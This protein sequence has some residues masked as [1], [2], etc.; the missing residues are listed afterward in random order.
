MA[1]DI[2]TLIRQALARQNGFDPQVRSK[3]Y[4]SSRNA[5]AKMIAKSGVI[6]PNVIDARNRSLEDTIIRIEREFTSEVPLQS[7][8]NS[9]DIG[10][11]NIG[12]SNIEQS[13]NV[14]PNIEQSNPEQPNI[15]PPNNGSLNNGQTEFRHQVGATARQEA[16]TNPQD[17]LRKSFEPAKTASESTGLG[18]HN[19]SSDEPSVVAGN[20]QS[21]VPPVD[22]NRP[23][24]DKKPTPQL[25]PQPPAKDQQNPPSERAPAGL[26]SFLQNASSPAPPTSSEQYSEPTPQYARPR[27]KPIRYFIWVVLAAILLVAGWVAY[28]LTV[29]YLEPTADQPVVGQ[30]LQVLE[31]DDAAGF[32]T[33]LDPAQPG[34]LITAGN[35]T[36]EI[37][38]ETSQPAIRIMSVRKADA[39][40]IPAK[41]LLLELAPGILKNIA[42][43]KVTVEIMAKSG[44]SG[45]ATFAVSCDFGELGDCGRK[46][47]RIGLQPEAVVFSIQIS[48]DLKEGQR[49]FLAI[50]TDVTS[51]AA[52]SG[53]GAK[54]DIVYARIRAAG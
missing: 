31:T 43:K 53:K 34:A 36:A 2:E 7:T 32:V 3:I 48:A 30:N 12:H 1:A 49:A 11:P 51:A 39:S 10:L 47:F 6:P 52:I 40:D 4:Q 54:I 26:E 17:S 41:P 37:L 44:D 23:F 46:R 38:S 21:E 15:E 9:F 27:P 33:I 13:D 42:G 19:T 29:S 5:L 18:A 28:M 25:S 22:V 24:Y 20:R 8:P 45:A 50:S 16:E 35:G 14:L